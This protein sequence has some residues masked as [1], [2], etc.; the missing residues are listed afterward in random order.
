MTPRRFLSLLFLCLVLCLAMLL[1]A[2]C[3]GGPPPTPVER[4]EAALAS[5]DWRSAKSY[6]AEALQADSRLGRAWLGQSRALLAGRDPE[7]TLQS[8]SRLSEV[9]R[10]MFV[11]DARSIYAEGLDA[12]ARRRLL[13]QQNEAALGAVRAL[14][15]LEPARRGLDRLLGRA[16][17][18][19]AARQR[20]RG[21]PKTALELYR[22]A[23]KVVPNSLDAWL[24]AAE[25]LLESGQGKEAIRLLETAR[26]THPT[27]SQIRI[28]TIQAL[29]L[30]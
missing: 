13:R 20:W 26:K 30:R 6:F 23:C 11:R 24:G 21:D 28:L 1:G 9:D 15:K 14:A 3:V 10:A 8:L 18:G 27:A 25:I 29:G 16:L 7:G 17:I 19:E 22:E 5:G 12:A 4:G 2:G